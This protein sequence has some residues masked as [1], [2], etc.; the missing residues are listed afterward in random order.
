MVSA[1]GK[2]SSRYAYSY[3]FSYRNG[4]SIALRCLENGK[5]L[6]ALLLWFIGTSNGQDISYNMTVWGSAV[7]WHRF[8]I[9][10]A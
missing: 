4:A 5:P 8:S 9:A 1:C 2:N 7:K 6:T 3:I 10:A